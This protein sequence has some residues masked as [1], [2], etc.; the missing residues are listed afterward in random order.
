M[1]RLFVL[2]YTLLVFAFTP[3]LY[4]QINDNITEDEYVADDDGY[5]EMDDEYYDSEDEDTP[6]EEMDPI[7]QGDDESFGDY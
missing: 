1:Q 6:L 4:S 7:Y 3:T 2:I 5:D